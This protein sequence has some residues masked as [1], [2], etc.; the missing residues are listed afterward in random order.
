MLAFQA[1][2]G[3]VLANISFTKGKTTSLE[4]CVGE[5]GKKVTEER[6]K[7]KNLTKKIVLYMVLHNH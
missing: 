7:G 5:G 2:E 3:Y 6:K 1:S 4:I